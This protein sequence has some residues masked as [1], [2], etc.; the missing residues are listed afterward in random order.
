MDL[1]SVND[2]EAGVVLSQTEVVLA[3]VGR[4]RVAGAIKTERSE[5]DVLVLRS[6]TPVI[7]D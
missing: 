7:G 3:E 4:V 5:I 6:H 2:G 1:E